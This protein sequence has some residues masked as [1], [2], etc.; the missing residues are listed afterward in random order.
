MAVDAVGGV[1]AGRGKDDVDLQGAG[2]GDLAA[3][4]DV[5]AAGEAGVV[6]GGVHVDGDVDGG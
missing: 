3:V 5:G 6:A 4:L 1:D 2:A